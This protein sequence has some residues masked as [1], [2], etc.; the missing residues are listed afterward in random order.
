MFT[1]NNITIIGTIITETSKFKLP[2][3]P[4]AWTICSKNKN[5]NP[6]IKPA[7]NFNVVNTCLLVEEI[8]NNNPIKNI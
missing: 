3:I 2:V 6:V 4:I 8:E 7:N 5:V 1:E